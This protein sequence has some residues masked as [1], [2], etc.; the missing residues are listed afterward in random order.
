MYLIRTGVGPSV[1]SKS[2]EEKNNLSRLQEI[3]PELSDVQPLFKT[4]IL[5]S[6]K[7]IYEMLDIFFLSFCFG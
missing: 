1:R 5:L 7:I 6:V 4:L 2:F 3:Y